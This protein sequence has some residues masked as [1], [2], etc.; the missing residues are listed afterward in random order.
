MDSKLTSILTLNV[1]G[2]REKTKRENCFY[3]LK[4][5]KADIIFLQETYWTVDLL[6]TIEKEWEGEV[7]LSQGTYHSKGTAIL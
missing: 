6:K 1:R 5:Q 3:W 2:L 4:Q 7:L